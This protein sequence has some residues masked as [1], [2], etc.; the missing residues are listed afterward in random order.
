M[1]GVYKEAFMFLICV[2]SRETLSFETILTK[3]MYPNKAL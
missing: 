1:R 2:Y 3:Q